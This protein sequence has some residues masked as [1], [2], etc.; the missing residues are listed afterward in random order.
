MP[1]FPGW[2]LD[3]ECHQVAFFWPCFS[4]V[5][6]VAQVHMSSSSAWLYVVSSVCF[7]PSNFFRCELYKL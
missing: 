4:T 7:D 3:A 5:L 1:T 6:H 2:Q